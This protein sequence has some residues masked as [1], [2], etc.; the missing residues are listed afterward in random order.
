[1]TII[2]QQAVQQ[3][4]GQADL[5]Q[6][7]IFLLRGGCRGDALDALDPFGCSSVV[8]TSVIHNLPLRASGIILGKTIMMLLMMVMMM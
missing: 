6:Y 3:F 2:Q 1:M 5:L 7:C 8:I 4:K